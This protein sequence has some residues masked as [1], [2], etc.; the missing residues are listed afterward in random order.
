ML[1]YPIQLLEEKI[2]PKYECHWVTQ[3][4][5]VGPLHKA[6]TVLWEILALKLKNDQKEIAYWQNYYRLGPPESGRDIAENWTCP[7]CQHD[8]IIKWGTTYSCPNCKTHGEIY[9][10]PW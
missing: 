1:F 6:L 10:T 3:G 9:V 7:K 5:V 8:H 2:Y 4:W